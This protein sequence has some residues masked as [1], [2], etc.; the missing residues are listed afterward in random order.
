MKPTENLLTKKQ[1]A[2]RLAICQR[3]LE[4]L[5]QRRAIEAVKF[6]RCVRIH[7][8]AIT[9]FLDKQTINAA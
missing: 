3:S 4:T 1:A 7:P 2:A 9:A 6:M 8:D 5:I